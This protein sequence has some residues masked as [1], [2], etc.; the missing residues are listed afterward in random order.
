MPSFFKIIIKFA[1]YL[2]L[3]NWIKQI[4]ADWLYNTLQEWFIVFFGSITERICLYYQKW[5]LADLIVYVMKLERVNSG[6]KAGL[7]FT[8]WQLYKQ[9]QCIFLHKI[10][11][12]RFVCVLSSLSLHSRTYSRMIQFT[13]GRGF[14]YILKKKTN[15]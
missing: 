12:P 7:K 2:I 1:L 11:C 8:S 13:T 15:D 10:R 3:S 9:R 6:L 5:W 4:R 14:W